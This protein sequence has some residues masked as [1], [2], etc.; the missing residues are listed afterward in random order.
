MIK[1]FFLDKEIGKFLNNP[2]TE[3]NLMKLLLPEGNNS[4]LSIS[5]VNKVLSCNNSSINQNLLSIL[6]NVSPFIK[7]LTLQSAVTLSKLVFDFANP[8]LLLIDTNSFIPLKLLLDSI[9]NILIFNYEENQ[10]MIYSLFRQARYF[11]QLDSHI[12]PDLITVEKKL[13]KS[14]WISK[15]ENIEQAIL[16]LPLKFLLKILANISSKLEE[17]FAVDKVSEEELLLVINRTSL[18]GFIEDMPKFEAYHYASTSDLELWLS[19]YLWEKVYSKNAPLKLFYEDRIRYIP[20]QASKQNEKNIKERK[21]SQLKVVLG[22]INS[23][24]EK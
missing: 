10:I 7:R 22:K 24:E 3:K 2:I 23:E 8:K 17:I 6:F 20:T 9:A 4:D 19:L 11:N 13:K 5:L 12:F 16:H 14:G 15:G 21:E 1:Y 18:V